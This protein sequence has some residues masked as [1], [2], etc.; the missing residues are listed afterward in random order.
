MNQRTDPRRA[1]APEPAPDALFTGIRWGL[2]FA[3]LGFWLPVA[4]LV[5][6]GL[7]AS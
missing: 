1:R 6:R 7:S 5:S 2:L 3:L 4:L